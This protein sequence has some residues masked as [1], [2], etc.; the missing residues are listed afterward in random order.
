MAVAPTIC[1]LCR[2]LRLDGLDSTHVGGQLF[3]NVE[4]PA[5]DQILSPFRFL[6]GKE[7]VGD[8]QGSGTSGESDVSSS[9][10]ELRNI[11]ATPNVP[12]KLANKSPSEM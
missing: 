11:G 8:F 4:P 1:L 7:G 3:V 10:K 6:S 2:F 12:T 5:R 9:L